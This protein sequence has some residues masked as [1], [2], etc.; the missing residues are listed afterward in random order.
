[1]SDNDTSDSESTYESPFVMCGEKLFYYG[2]PVWY[3]DSSGVDR[4]ARINRILLGEH[5]QLDLNIR[6]DADVNKIRDRTS[7]VSDEDEYDFESESDV[8]S[9]EQGNV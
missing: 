6:E 4:K 8:S 9:S 2:Q 1:M 5:F 7:E 3:T